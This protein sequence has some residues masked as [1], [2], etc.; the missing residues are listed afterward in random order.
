[1]SN[2]NN[3]DKGPKADISF[4]SLGGRKVGHPVPVATVSGLDFSSLGGVCVFPP[5]KHPMFDAKLESKE[6]DNA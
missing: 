4:E 1:M 5:N 2:E 6:A 3:N